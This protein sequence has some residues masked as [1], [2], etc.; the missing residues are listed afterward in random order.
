MNAQYEIE[1]STLHQTTTEIEQL[2]LKH[3][4]LNDEITK[5]QQKIATLESEKPKYEK[6]EERRKTKVSRSN[7]FS[8]WTLFYLVII[9]AVFY[10][11]L[12]SI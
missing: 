3:R 5:L 9:I 12:K 11:F 2:A 7:L 8:Y 4:S 10:Y 6:Q 1:K